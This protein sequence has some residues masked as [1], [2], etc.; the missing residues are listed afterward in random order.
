MKVVR[1]DRKVKTIGILGGWGSGKSTIVGL[2]Q[3]MFNE[4]LSGP[5]FH[6]F[7]YDAWL[8]QSDPP[9][10][11]FLEALLAFLKTADGMDHIV[12]SE[13]KWKKTLKKLN[14]QIE[15]NKTTVTPTL[16]PA[17]RWYLP[18]LLLLPLGIRLVGDGVLPAS[19]QNDPAGILLFVIGWLLCLAPVITALI[20]YILWRPKKSSIFSKEF[21]T[22]HNEN[23]KD[24]SI[25]SVIA[26]RSVERKRELKTK[27]PDPTAIEFQK[28]FRK[29]M[30]A[31]QNDDHR[32]VIIIDN[33]DRLTPKESVVIW[34]TIRSFFL[35]SDGGE[36]VDRSKL[37]TVIVP[38]DQASIARIY[39]KESADDLSKSFVD[40]TFDLVFH[41]PTPVLSRWHRYLNQRIFDVFGVGVPKEWPHVVG[42]IYE[43]YLAKTK[44]R[45]SPRSINK[46]VNDI[47]VSWLLFS[48][49]NIN[50]GIIAYFV[51]ERKDISAD[52]YGHLTAE[53]PYLDRIDEEW[54]TSIAALHF[55]VTKSEAKEL[56]ME[57]PIRDSMRSRSEEDFKKLADVPG[58]ERYFLKVV[59]N[60][61]HQDPPF[62]VL[63]AA[64]TLRQMDASL[65]WVV[66]AWSE[67]RQISLGLMPR[68]SFGAGDAEAVMALIASCNQATVP[69][70][71]RALAAAISNVPAKQLI[72]GEAKFFA[73]VAVAL[74][75]SA[76]A[77]SLDDF[78]VLISGGADDLLFIVSCIPTAETARRVRLIGEDPGAISAYII[79]QLRDTAGIFTVAS[80]IRAI[81]A[82]SGDEIDWLPIF[83]TLGEVLQS[84]DPT[85]LSP[86]A[87]IVCTL[88]SLLPEMRNRTEM[89]RDQGVLERAFHVAWQ[90]SDDR[91]L[92]DLTALN[93]WIEGSTSSPDGRSWEDKLLE[94]PDVP[95]MID[96]ACGEIDRFLT[97]TW[98][99]RRGQSRPAELPLL[100]A[101]TARHLDRYI[102][103][104]IDPGPL[105]TEAAGFSAILP[106]ELRPRFWGALS[107]KKDFWNTLDELPIN[108]AAPV[109]YA[110]IDS[111][112]SKISVGKFLK[113]R[114]NLPEPMDW[115][116]PIR[117]GS[118]PFGLVQA[119]GRL[120][121]TSVTVG[122]SAER[123]LRSLVGDLLASGDS[124]FRRRWF[125]VASRLSPSNRSTLYK[126]LRDALTR[127]DAV[128]D[129]EN[130]LIIAGSTVLVEGE[131][132][133]RADG[134]VLHLVLPLLEQATGRSW[135][136]LNLR[137][138]EPWIAGCDSSTRATLIQHLNQKREA[139][140][141]NAAELFD[142]LQLRA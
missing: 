62:P 112:V 23:H 130:L 47:A 116:G 80:S 81:A 51:C 71:L 132:A 11:S 26:N 17:G 22:T 100:K 57:Q 76:D 25:I 66:E 113:R 69:S 135:L 74:I 108:V 98:L 60:G 131:F 21:W 68:L 63:G 15:K 59:K 29:I 127:G 115:D 99:A 109:L 121:R 45:P 5:R 53:N 114:L 97:L 82:R 55:G 77:A 85:R 30:S 32:I 122:S 9:R 10:R 92:A 54:R 84:G 38:I 106:T 34:S 134:S 126:V 91:M 96:E 50:I 137:D 138:V 12:R 20:I 75:S 86:A 19:K 83:D 73:D 72:Q 128:V 90:A 41:V 117:T 110:V 141:A 103:E 119:L 139:G 4:N 35:G 64:A 79:Q 111:D 101:I 18:T 56:F 65:P 40:K 123:H 48:N 142:A 94:K 3:N 2:V 61:M 7:T 124:E 16:S 88:S 133:K 105:L 118:E 49:E 42:D 58:F 95:Q 36:R 1:N 129:L 13:K 14:N 37:P 6:C 44:E 107:Q 89:W 120:E 8:Y 104:I 46:Y 39:D 136:L 67:L 102:S 78:Q 33:L 28:A 140:E 24:D 87:S 31:A 27:S 93:F 70:F 125:V 43:T 52:I